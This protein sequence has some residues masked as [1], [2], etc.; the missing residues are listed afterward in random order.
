MAKRERRWVRTKAIT[1]EEK[2][3]VA[4]ICE[5]FVAEVLKPRILPEIRRTQ[6]NYPIEIF[7]KWRGSKYSFI[8]RYRSGFSDNLGAEFDSALIRLDHLEECLEETRFDVMWRR[9]TGQW[10]CLYPSVGLEEALRLIETEPLL[11]AIS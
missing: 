1:K 6:F 9:Y 10:W 7:G 11:Q 4:A 3:A 8:A 2:E 5:R